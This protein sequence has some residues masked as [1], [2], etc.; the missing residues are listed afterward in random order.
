M[1]LLD[2]YYLSSRLTIDTTDILQW[3]RERASVHGRC[4]IQHGWFSTVTAKS[5]A[6]DLISTSA[7]Y[8]PENERWLASPNEN[9]FRADGYSFW[10]AV[11]TCSLSDPCQSCYCS[12]CIAGIKCDV[13]REI[14]QARARRVQYWFVSTV[15]HVGSIYDEC[16]R[17][18]FLK[19]FYTLF[20]WHYTPGSRL[21]IFTMICVVGRT[22]VCSSAPL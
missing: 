2:A 8:S 18:Y 21:H 20:I 3:H 7:A 6:Q 16:N 4:A 19:Q 10:R 9:D 12:G 14:L 13:V 15:E 5:Q 17:E 11:P 22:F 1:A